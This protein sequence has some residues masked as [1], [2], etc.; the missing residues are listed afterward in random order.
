MKPA[1]ES[2][3]LKLTSCSVLGFILIAVIIATSMK[4]QRFRNG[5]ILLPDYVHEDTLIVTDADW[6]NKYIDSTGGDG[7][8]ME[9]LNH[10]TEKYAL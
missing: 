1:T 2:F 8:I 3:L 9:L 7:E 10:S 6:L 5:D 4:E